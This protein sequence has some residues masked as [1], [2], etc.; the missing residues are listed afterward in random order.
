M[1]T[2]ICRRVVLLLVLG[3]VLDAEN[4]LPCFVHDDCLQPD[5]FCAW[6][7]CIGRAGDSYSCGKCRSCDE[8][9]CDQ[10]STDFHCPVIRCPAQPINGVR[11][12]QGKFDSQSSLLETPDFQCIRQLVVSGNVFS[13]SQRPIYSLHPAITAI[14]NESDAAILACPSFSRS[15]VLGGLQVENGQIRLDVIVSSEGDPSTI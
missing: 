2:V 6:S 14:L 7:T 5:Q 13:I 9:R 15:G 8:C 4:S 1:L 10:D 12:L 3:V 11:Y